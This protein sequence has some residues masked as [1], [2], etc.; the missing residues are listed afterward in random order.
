MAMT[1]MTIGASAIMSMQKASVQGN[2]DARKT[3]VA[4]AIARTW[5]ERLKRDS[6]QW[7]SPDNF[8]SAKLL[9]GNVTNQWFLP[10]QYVGATPETMSPGFDILGRDLKA[11]HIA[12]AVFCTHV[13]LSWLANNSLLRA[14]VRVLWGRGVTGTAPA[15]F[16]ATAPGDFCT[17]AAPG[18][19]STSSPDPAIYASIYATTAL[20]ENAQ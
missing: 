17:Q 18:G 8:A 10:T 3:D 2:L 16:C 7:T 4:N 1:V 6:M 20:R 11:A 12:S 5:I 14:D 15:G 9:S 19:T 13:C